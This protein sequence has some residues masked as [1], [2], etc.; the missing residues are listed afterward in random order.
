MQKEFPWHVAAM[1]LR[2]VI[3]HMVAR[4]KEKGFIIQI[5]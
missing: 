2:Y 1:A 3:Q 5:L 4:D